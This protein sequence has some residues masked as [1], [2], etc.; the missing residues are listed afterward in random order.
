MSLGNS[1]ER[2]IADDA[3]RGP[4]VEAVEL[5]A[6]KLAVDA[7]G[8]LLRLTTGSALRQIGGQVEEAGIIATLPRADIL[9]VKP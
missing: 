1:E 7:H 3:H 4:V 5:I 6:L 2:D 8:Q 9:I